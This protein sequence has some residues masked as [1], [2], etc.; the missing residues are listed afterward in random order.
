M[1][2]TLLIVAGLFTVGTPALA[3]KNPA[4]V[5]CVVKAK[6]FEESQVC[7]GPKYIKQRTPEEVEAEYR[8]NI[9]RDYEIE[10]LK[11]QNRFNMDMESIRND[12]ALIR[13]GLL[14]N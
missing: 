7:N 3:A 4:Y 8:A 13:S 10:D 2:I 5:D 9:Y 1:R 6:T 14:P 11:A 12:R